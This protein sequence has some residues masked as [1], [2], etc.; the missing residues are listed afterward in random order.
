MLNDG[1]GPDQEQ[2]D[3]ESQPQPHQYDEWKHPIQIQKFSFDSSRYGEL[4]KYDCCHP[5]NGLNGYV[6][7]TQSPIQ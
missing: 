1:G 4:T 3:C 7:I 2:N 5:N 6:W